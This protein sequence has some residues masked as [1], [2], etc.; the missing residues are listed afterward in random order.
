M[1]PLIG[2]LGGTAFKKN[3]SLKLGI[4]EDTEHQS[5]YRE[6]LDSDGS[7]ILILFVPG[8]FM[9]PVSQVEQLHFLSSG[10]YTTRALICFKLAWAFG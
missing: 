5:S 6:N 9:W 7:Q 8:Y 4:A 10:P 1:Q 2:I 3:I